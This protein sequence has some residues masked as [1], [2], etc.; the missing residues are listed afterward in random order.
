MSRRHVKRVLSKVL[1]KWIST[2]D[3]KS[4][5]SVVI[6]DVYIAG[7]AVNSIMT[8][9]K[10]N[11]YDIYF[12]TR[13][14]LKKIL[15]YYLGACESVNLTHCESVKGL[16]L[17]SVKGRSLKLSGYLNFDEDEIE[18]A[19]K[20]KFVSENA[21]T[22][23]NK[24][25]IILKFCGMP[26][27]VITYF[28]FEHAKCFYSFNTNYTKFSPEALESML[29]KQLIYTGSKYPLASLFRMRKF[30]RRDWNISAGQI[31]KIAMNLQRFDLQDLDVL[32][33]QLL[34]V[35]VSHMGILIDA[36]QR[37]TNVEYSYICE[38][39]DKIFIEKGDESS[40]R[41]RVFHPGLEYD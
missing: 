39:I 13:E 10:I 12:K 22:L 26:E 24:M 30:L 29:T 3:D 36:I 37:G 27:N 28:D 1:T 34:G 4:L 6:R 5:R 41:D 18:T 8:G 17:Q 32:K 2:I 25:Q 9:D 40:N 7:G 38:L 20:P 35:D 15:N 16:K 11:D 23:T 31:V 14:T 33:D 21:L 19:Y